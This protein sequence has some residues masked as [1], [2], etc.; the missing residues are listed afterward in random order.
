MKVMIPSSRLKRLR[1]SRCDSTVTI[2]AVAY[3][4]ENPQEHEVD[5][6]DPILTAPIPRYNAMLAVLRNT[7]YM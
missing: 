2:V 5:P 3:L 4:Y 7:L 6:D 1:I